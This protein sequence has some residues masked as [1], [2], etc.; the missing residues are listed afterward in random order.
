MEYVIH[1]MGMPFNGETLKHKSLGGSETAAYYFGKELAS[2]GHRVVMFTSSQEQGEFDGVTYCWAGEADQHNPLGRNFA[3]YACDTPHDVLIIQRHPMGFHKD[4]A[5]KINVLQMHD[6]ALHRTAGMLN[7]G[8][9]RVDLVTGVSQFHVDQMKSVY[10]IH[11][12]T[13]RVVPNGV[14]LDL[15]ADDGKFVALNADLPVGRVASAHGKFKLLYQSRPERGLIH[16]LRP[17]GIMERLAD[18]SDKFHLYYCAYQNTVEHMVDF[19]RELEAMAARLPNVTNLGALS[20]IDLAAVQQKCDMLV[21][22]TEFEEVSCITAMEAMAAGLPFLSSEHAALPETCKDSGA[23]LIPFKDGGVSEDAFVFEIMRHEANPD[24]LKAAREKQLQAA[25]SRGWEDAVDA[26]EDAVEEVFERRA[27]SPARVARHLIEHSDI[28]ALDEFGKNTILVEFPVTNAIEAKA[29]EERKTMYAF[30][31]SLEATAEHYRKWEGMNCDR[32]E[33]VG[34]TPEV[35]K[36]SVITSTRFRG[37]AHLLA[38]SV[39]E[40][41]NAGETVRVLEFGCAHGHITMAL[42]E[43]LPKVEFIGMDFMERSVALGNKHAAERKL[44]NVTFVQGSLDSLAALEP[45]DVVIAPEVIEHIWDW[46]GAVNSLLGALKVGGDLITTT[47]TGR[48]EWSGRHWWHKGR[49]HLHHFE[50]ADLVDIFEEF[51]T[52][53]YQAPA[54]ADPTGQAHGSWVL[55]ATKSKDAELRDI[56]YGRKFAT[57]APRDTVSLCM[58]VKNAQESIGRALRSVVDW[59][60]EVVIALDE[61]TD[62]RTR[63]RIAEVEADFPNVAFTVF[64]AKSPLEIGFDAARN[65]TI[66]RSCGD[67]IFW[68]DADEEVVGANNIIRLLR[69]GAFDGYAIAQHHM[70]QNPASCIATDYPSRLFRRDSGAKFYGV[71]HEHPETEIG[72]AIPHTHS[73]G[74]ISIVHHGYVDEGT[75][76]GRYMRNWPLLLKDL[77]KNPNRKLNQFLYLRDLAQ[78]L[79]F[80]GQQTG[81]VSEHMLLDAKRAVEIFERMID[82]MPMLRMVLDAIPYYSAA[83]SALGPGFHAKV[84]VTTRKDELPGVSAVANLE[85]YFHNIATYT[86]LLAR[87]AKET[88][89]NYEAK[90]I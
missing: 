3:M 55:R 2:R 79:A 85:G 48:W 58:I 82:E 35:E 44:T 18:Q 74:D 36:Q 23:I 14:D 56:D 21:Y 37:I 61:K 64:P 30:A 77:E 4:Y 5:S 59:V 67:W 88:T 19:Y 53:I 69:P 13:L 49:E 8:L 40:K 32:M 29:L 43:Q 15:Y 68:M 62:D 89:V 24:L 12:R 57:L 9:G 22:P 72:K 10:G 11:D 51:E 75:R 39:A 63:E 83:A 26:F 46:K 54:G 87:I 20:K 60:D 70:S 27:Q 7:A 73:A 65:A 34:L 25:E 17:G 84:A 1:S 90:Y 38:E 6:L 78:G 45:F 31:E 47:P 41:I 76:R 42:A 81:A 52:K 86:R 28:S 71:V 16:L 66:E 80:E 33:Q 50:R